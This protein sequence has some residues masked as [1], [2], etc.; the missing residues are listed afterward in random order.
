MNAIEAR[1]DKE[2]ISQDRRS[3]HSNAVTLRSRGCE[4]DDDDEKAMVVKKG[5]WIVRKFSRFRN[6]N[7]NNYMCKHCLIP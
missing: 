4:N 3:V 2:R 6:E 5:I 1:E 7:R